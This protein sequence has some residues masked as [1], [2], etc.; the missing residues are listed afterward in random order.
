MKLVSSRASDTSLSVPLRMQRP[1]TR[2]S[3]ARRLAR[4]ALHVAYVLTTPVPSHR[5]VTVVTL[6]AVV[7]VVAEVSAVVAVAVVVAEA[8]VDLVTEVVV[9]AAVV[10]VVE[11]LPAVAAA[12]PSPVPRSPLTKCGNSRACQMFYQRDQCLSRVRLHTD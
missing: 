2:Q 9:V 8:V 5:R 11:D 12:H 3:L 1:F 6:V 4:A 7:V 10:V